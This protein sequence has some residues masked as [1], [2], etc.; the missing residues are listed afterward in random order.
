[1]YFQ[2]MNDKNLDRESESTDSA[3][4]FKAAEDKTAVRL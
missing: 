4:S 3:R 2:L 1:M